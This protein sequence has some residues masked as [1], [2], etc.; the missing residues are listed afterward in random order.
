MPES[1]L[2]R[3]D[4][5]NDYREP[6][7]GWRANKPA[8]SQEWVTCPS[9][10]RVL[11]R[12]LGTEDLISAG[13]L[14]E[15]D[16]MIAMV[17]DKHLAKGGAKAEAVIASDPEMIGKM[18]MIMDRSLPHILVRPAVALHFVDVKDD[19][20]RKTT[21]RLT[22]AERDPSLVYTDQIDLADKSFLTQW[23]MGR[24]ADQFRR[25]PAD[26]LAGLADGPRVPG[27]GKRPSRNG[28]KRR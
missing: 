4:T 13:L 26:S 17:Q 20:G 23:A 7:A 11:A 19:A 10:E 28:R 5:P 12:R 21:R 27:K 9:G 8:G 24:V 14:A 1:K 3:V 15:R 16:T 25:Q 2:N 22:E 18:V 6:G